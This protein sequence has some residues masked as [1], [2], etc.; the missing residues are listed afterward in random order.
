MLRFAKYELG[1]F[2]IGAHAI[3][4]VRR[5]VGDRVEMFASQTFT[6]VLLER[7]MLIV[8]YFTS[9]KSGQK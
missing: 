1:P 4:G 8:E 7:Y 6:S 2:L 3:T 5:R 9:R